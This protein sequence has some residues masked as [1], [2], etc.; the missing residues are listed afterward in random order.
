[1]SHA[2]APRLVRAV[3]G[4]LVASAL[5]ASA[6]ARSGHA[7]QFVLV[8]YTISYTKAMADKDA[9][10]FFVRDATGLN[11]ARPRNW[12]A[13]VN[14]RNGTVHIR[15]EVL[16]KP[17]GG[18]TTQWTLCYMPN[19]PTGPGY[20]CTGSGTYKEQGA[21]V[22]RQESMTSWWQNT[23]IVWTEGIK[24]MHFVIK[25]SDGASGHAHK[26]A[27]AQKFFPTKVRITMV[28]VSAG[29]QFDASQ[30]PGWGAGAADGGAGDGGTADAGSATGGTGGNSGAG[31]ST[32]S[33]GV[34]GGPAGTGG[35]SAGASG[36]SPGTGGGAVTT[37]PGGGSGGAPAGRGGSTGGNS[38]GPSASGS[39]SGS[40][41]CSVGQLRAPASGT[42]GLLLAVGCLLALRRRRRS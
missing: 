30:V 31:G 7:E 33:G 18:E 5:L 22:I 29:A 42:A 17:A 2:F 8:D 24:E 15:T 13:P 11:P 4:I 9:S 6:G 16:E 41:G 28:Q 14:F 38:P 23:G 27:D 37:P 21:V 20:G 12:M 35:N 3:G 25:D 34:S 40:A 39:D 19:R 10:H 36:G 32:G 26:R 1:M